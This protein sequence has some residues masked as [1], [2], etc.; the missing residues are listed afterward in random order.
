MPQSRSL[1]LTAAGLLVAMTT[2]AAAQAD[3]PEQVRSG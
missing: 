1:L 2:M 3:Y